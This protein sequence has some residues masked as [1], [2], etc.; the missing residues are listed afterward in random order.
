MHVGDPTPLGWLTTF[1]YLAA[2]ALCLRAWR[3]QPADGGGGHPS[4]A[5][6]LVGA[7]ML[8]LGLNKQLDLQTQLTALGK[9]A[10][11]AGGWYEQRRTVQSWFVRLLALG[12]A[13]AASLGV[14]LWR[15]HWREL[16]APALGLLLVMAYVLLRA[17]RFQH[18]IGDDGR[19][20]FLLELSGIAVVGF[21]AWRFL[22]SRAQA[23]APR[24]ADV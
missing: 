18:V 24:D 19:G 8:A 21:G 15:R 7:L 5:W 17:A 11:H 23:Q 14:F 13:V 9:L 1:A 6:A 2:A 16:L 22:R 20:S 3:M 12:V 4:L 10:A